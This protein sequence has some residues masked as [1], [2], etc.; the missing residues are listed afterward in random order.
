MTGE[1]GPA[2]MLVVGEAGVGKSQLVSAAAGAA[3][4]A[5]VLVLSGWCVWASAALPFL[6]V[7][8]VLRQLGQVDEGRL[9]ES[10][11]S[12][13]PRYVRAEVGLLMPELDDAGERPRSAASD[14]EWGRQQLFDALRRLLAELARTRRVAMVIEDVHWADATTL[15]FLDYLLAPGRAPGFGV[16]LTC[17]SEEAPSQKLIEWLERLQRNAHIA[18]LDLAPLTRAETAEQI[19]LLLGQRPLEQFVDVMFERSEGN[20]FFTEQLV[21]SARADDEDA[22]G[23][24][25]IP[26]G[27]RSLLLS[28]TARLTGA[29]REVIV[30]L[31]IA[32]RPL[33]EQDLAVVSGSPGEKVREALRD[34]LSA[35]LLR[36]P[37]SAGRYQLRH[38]LLGEA[39][40]SELLADER[41]EM[42]GRVAEL[43]ESW[44]DT[45]MAAQIAEQLDGAKRP[46]K[47]LRWRLIAAQHA[48][49][50]YAWNEAL[51]QWQRALALWN[52]APDTGSVHGLD[53]VETY[54]RAQ[55]SAEYAGDV[56]GGGLAEE[57][58]TRFAVTASRET[59]LRLYR[60]VGPT[61]GKASVQAGM[62][63]LG[64]AIKLG[65]A[66]PPSL[67]YLTAL[68]QYAG[69]LNL[70][71]KLSL[72]RP[73]LASALEVARQ[74]G[75]RAQEKLLRAELAWLAVSEG[76]D[77]VLTELESAVQLH[78][79]PE[80]PPIEVLVTLDYADA[81]RT[82]G[83]LD[84]SVQ[85]S[86]PAILRAEEHGLSDWWAVNALRCV[87]CVALTERG[88]IDRATTIIDPVT[89]RNPTQD[90]RW[91][92][93]ERATLDMCRGR[94]AA[95]AA[96]W[97]IDQLQ[98]SAEDES[99]MRGLRAV[100]RIELDLWLGRAGRVLPE[101]FFVLEQL[102]RS[103]A[104]TFGG[105][106]LVLAL[107][108]CADDA[109]RARATGDTAELR[110]AVHGGDQLA[111]LLAGAKSDPFAER[112][113]P[114]D[115]HAF[116]LSWQAESGRLRG[117]SDAPAWPEAA[118]AWDALSRPHRAAYARWRHAQVLLA[119]SRNRSAAALLLRT[120]AAQAVQH[121]PLSN[122]IGVLARRARIE[123]SQPDVPAPV[124]Q[125][126]HVSAFGLT[127][128]ERAVLGLLGRGKTNPQIATALFIS[129]R[130]ASTHV[131]NILRKLDVATRVQAATVAE[132][133]GLLDE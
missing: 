59:A 84:R 104:S 50:V 40:G 93:V 32:A 94:L 118:V 72:Q 25:A 39:V 73:V 42:H 117:A 53:L 12:E 52:D 68:R 120:A 97:D 63:A 81:L 106:L 2:T 58:M 95:A 33:R 51:A 46:G 122:A 107:R 14:G 19:A 74:I 71:H 38:A 22:G 6:P 80:D 103:D 8:D 11:L 28:R 114:A 18:R 131:S 110:N 87:A 45:T 83:A 133:S 123:L 82:L 31:A 62:D 34:L 96:F 30:A 4:H 26:A 24:G 85:V 60:A 90:T 49:A 55:T 100:R 66:L 3:G 57:A 69:L 116:F 130:T 124:D 76:N 101:A 48:E 132:R 56:V 27:L 5:H 127:E 88:D 13:S 75:N 111:R 128:R 119:S 78:V 16:V 35:R 64:M 129:P 7:S 121:V 98:P 105:S 125:P 79:E 23:R 36:Q 77:E 102:C 44:G 70:Q 20:A 43:M 41:L 112:R 9:V 1:T 89:D 99:D 86:L 54:L 126:V 47:E 91:L 113:V 108:A 115:A 10:V 65:E 37:D 61:R 21:T 92:Y 17:R 109:E 67:E 29:A 15:E